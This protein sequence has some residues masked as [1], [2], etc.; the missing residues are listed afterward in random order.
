LLSYRTRPNLSRSAWSVLALLLS[1]PGTRAILRQEPP[2]EVI[3]SMRPGGI[4]LQ[5]KSVDIGPKVSEVFIHVYVVP[6]G[7]FGGEPGK[8]KRE[9]ITGGTTIADSPFYLD[10]F[11]EIN[12]KLKRVSTT[13]FIEDGDV[14]QIETRWLHPTEKQGPVILLRFGVGDSGEWKLV[15][16]P[17]GIGGKSFVQSIGFGGDRTYSSMLRFDLVDKRGVMMVREE[18]EQFE[19]GKAH[20]V[21]FCKWNGRKFK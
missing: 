14:N 11:R 19:G 10:L 1:L 16:Y 12:G 13:R 17:D 8:I 2:N 7:K 6:T 20:K 21:S 15:A 5:W 4:S 9:E 18:Y 3:A